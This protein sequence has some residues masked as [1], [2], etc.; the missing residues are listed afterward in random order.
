MKVVLYNDTQNA[1][2]NVHFGCRSVTA[3]FKHLLRQHEL[4]GSVSLDDARAGKWDREL[5][6][7]ADLVIAN[8]EGSFHHGKRPDFIRLA[9]EYPT[10]LVNT[11]YDGNKYTRDQVSQFRYISARESASA[12]QIR[13]LGVQCDVVP[14]VIF[15]SP[16]LKGI[17]PANMGHSIKIDHYSGLRTMQSEL[18]VVPAIAS[19]SSIITG[20]F[21][22]AL[23][24]VHF[25]KPL[26]LWKSNSIKNNGLAQDLGIQCFDTEADAREHITSDYDA[27]YADRA[28]ERIVQM[29]EAL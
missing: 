19:A 21:H 4:I 27:T 13:A 11:V 3:A 29:I 24:A 9:A 26:G 16:V 6:N 8:G 2:G 1:F 23:L 17:K 25:G 12:D 15:C 14:D 7:Q 5:L 22:A 18:V 28:R 10:A 20:S